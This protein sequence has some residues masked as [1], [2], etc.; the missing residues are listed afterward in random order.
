MFN[1]INVLVFVNIICDVGWVNVICWLVIFV[2]I[3]GCVKI[4]ND[5]VIVKYIV[6]ND[7]N[8]LIM[9]LGMKCFLGKIEC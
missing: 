6:I 7:K 9:W 1:V 4:E 3:I 2:I 8:L 5:V